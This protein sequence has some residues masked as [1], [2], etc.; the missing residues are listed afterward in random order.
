MFLIKNMF[1]FTRF[2]KGTEPGRG[3][4]FDIDMTDLLEMKR[5]RRI[6]FASAVFGHFLNASLVVFV[7]VFLWFF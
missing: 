7:I 6:V 2:V 3:T 4:G 1:S 5:C